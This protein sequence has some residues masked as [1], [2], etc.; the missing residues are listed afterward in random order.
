[1]IFYLGDHH[2][3]HLAT[4]GVPLFVSHTRLVG[5][6]T[7]PRA[8]APHARDSGGFTRLLTHG[9]WDDL[10]PRQYVE[11][12]RLFDREVGSA[13]FIA[14]QDWMCEAIM[15]KRT[16]L[17]IEKHQQLTTANYLELRQIAPDLPFIPVLQGWSMYDYWRHADDY[18]AHGVDL[19]A[20]P[21]VGVGTVC[22]RQ[23]TIVAHN[24][25]TSLAC[26]GFKLHAFGFKTQGL[27]MSANALESSDSLAWS[28][29]ARR[30]PP[31]PGC[32]HKNCANC[33]K[34]ALKWRAALLD[35]LAR[36][37]SGQQLDM[38]AG[39]A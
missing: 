12:N 17:S 38:F 1:M 37:R 21:R 8:I 22:R 3:N 14:P 26:T 36:A 2:P 4:A 11:D 10:S 32:T 25:L 31:M 16:G 18:I 27:L 23:G 13:D 35:R 15:L 24:I 39:A 20:L 7:F 33:L 30:E 9:N 29:A 6:K 28:Y 34:Y 19:A 5:R